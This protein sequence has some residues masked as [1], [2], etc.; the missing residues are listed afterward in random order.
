V[1]IIISNS[2]ADPIYAQ[3]LSQIRDAIIRGELKPG[4]NLPSIRALARDLNI[5]A[6]TTK[7]AYDDLESAGFVSSV[8]GKGTFVSEA[9]PEI[10]RETRL[11]LIEEKLSEAVVIGKS[12]GLGVRDMVSMLEIQCGEE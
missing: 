9:K 7:R 4:D 3:I 1:N 11:R 8:G 12:I 5:S 10:M 2:S 6:I